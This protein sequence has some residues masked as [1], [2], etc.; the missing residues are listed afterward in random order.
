LLVLGLVSAALLPPAAL[1][2]I[3]GG[4]TL[5]LAP[6]TGIVLATG[7][8]VAPVLVMLIGGRRARYL[9]VPVG[10]SEL[11]HAL[12]RIAVAAGFILYV[13]GYS[14]VGGGDTVLPS[15]MIAALGL[16]CS[17]LV[18]LQIGLSPAP[19]ALR[20]RVVAAGD[21][22]LVSALIH[23]GGELAAPWFPLYPAIAM[24]AG[25]QFGLRAL[26]AATA[27]GAG[28]FAIAALATPF[29]RGLPTMAVGALA[30]IVLVPLQLGRWLAQRQRE[31]DAAAAANVARDRT[32]MAASEDVR[33][34]LKAVLDA[35][36]S[37]DRAGLSSQQSDRLARLRLGARAALMQN[38]A[39]PAYLA[40]EAGNFAP[41]T[42]GFDLYQLVHGTIAALRPQAV[43][44]GVTL[45]VRIDPRLPYELRGWPHQLRQ[46]LAGLVAS[47]VNR[48][49]RSTIVITL[50]LVE[51]AGDDVR[52][53][54]GI[55]DHGARVARTMTR[56]AGAEGRPELAIAERLAGMMGGRI[57][58]G[59]SPGGGLSLSVEL[60]FAIDRAALALAL[61]LA[62]LTVFI[63]SEDQQLARE[64]IGALA[65]W[66]AVGRWIGAGE[67][68]LAQVA[69]LPAMETRPALIVDGRGEVL[70]ALSWAHRAGRAN[71]AA[72]PYLLFIADES[73]IDSVIGLADSELDAI[74][75]APFTPGVLQ[76]TLH[77]LRV[78]TAD[79]FPTE[80]L[81]VP[82][83]T[84]PPRPASPSAAPES[85]SSAERGALPTRPAPPRRPPPAAT[86]R[87]HLQVLVVAGNAANRKIIERILRTAGHVPTLV[88]DSDQA[89]EILAG[90]PIDLVLL[91]A[92][93]A[94]SAAVVTCREASP[95]VPII[96]L[97]AAADTVG[98]AA[99]T[100]LAKPVEPSRMLAAI[101][102]I[103]PPPA[104]PAAESE[105][106][107]DAAA[108]VTEISSHPRFA[109]GHPGVID[110]R[111]VDALVSLG[112]GSGFF[113]DVVDSF[114]ADT[115]QLLKEI[116]GA[117]AI[118][119]A[120]GFAAA[121]HALRN[122][123]ASLGGLG[124]RQLLSA[125]E[126]VG[127]TELRRRGSALVQQLGA[128]VDRLEATL[129]AYRQTR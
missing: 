39:I 15:L 59:P 47:A 81:P 6:R 129:A 25:L 56:A 121:L 108:V 44:R 10:Q 13:L 65:S 123:T 38:D 18:L 3:P 113:D 76:S 88:A 128:E 115:R 84:P 67:D 12:V 104:T 94:D 43:E 82:A 51:L 91:D 99:T 14:V 45:S 31:V 92:A 9:P 30:V 29:W 75:P 100:V 70:P 63:A 11:R 37:F 53:T 8:V 48:T 49:D 33:R 2:A 120:D 66:H 106:P 62:G 127:P 74:L 87:W 17:W 52:F 111:A 57:E 110:E 117:A 112:A 78:G 95:E 40:I 55:A 116:G 72:A 54:L 118:G 102:D 7:M 122:C 79:W 27:I 105:V 1:S 126:Q 5:L 36:A 73:R 103:Y 97:S 24:T 58:I 42:R 32:L 26:T 98:G 60:T 28:A 125:M 50:D 35:A 77:A 34:S 124:L 4:L 64:L 109:G 101:N 80:P 20:Y 41:E 93:G 89:A 21:I 90:Q 69:A 114:R 107:A 119:D 61:D 68:A 85:S 71:P 22:A 46:V 83:L 96:V 23:A 19:S 16:A 86:S